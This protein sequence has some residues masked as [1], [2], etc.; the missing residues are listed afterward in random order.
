MLFSQY[1]RDNLIIRILYNQVS[2]STSVNYVVGQN[3]SL[4][5]QGHRI[6]TARHSGIQLFHSGFWLSMIACP[7]LPVDVG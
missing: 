7:L 1:N 2:I 5:M 3:A 4:N 6:T